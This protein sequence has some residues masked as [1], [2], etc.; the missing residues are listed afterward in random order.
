MTFFGGNRH[1]G[2]QLQH[3]VWRLARGEGK[4]GGTVWVWRGWGGEGEDGGSGGPGVCEGG[5]GGGHLELLEMSTIQHGMIFCWFNN[6]PE[7]C[8]GTAEMRVHRKQ[9]LR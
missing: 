2:K 3:T 7:S 1:A 6:I 5:G 9:P 8:Y 4:E